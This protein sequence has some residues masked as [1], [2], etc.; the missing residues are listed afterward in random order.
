M[1]LECGEESKANPKINLSF[2]DL[3]WGPQK[4]PKQLACT[5]KENEAKLGTFVRT[6]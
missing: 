5:P 2:W 4:Q 6:L 1:D 3:R